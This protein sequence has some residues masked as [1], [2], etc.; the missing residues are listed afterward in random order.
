MDKVSTFKSGVRISKRLFAEW[1]GSTPLY[2]NP[3]RHRLKVGNNGFAGRL[4]CL[5][6]SNARFSQLFEMEFLKSL[7][8]WFWLSWMHRL[9]GMFSTPIGAL[10]K[11]NDDDEVA[12][13]QWSC[14]ICSKVLFLVSSSLRIR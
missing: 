1:I 11:N 5:E 4:S 10:K 7:N 14:Q 13:V 2:R 3:M 9:C 12:A 6:H 8:V